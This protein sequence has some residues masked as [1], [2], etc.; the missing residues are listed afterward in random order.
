MNKAAVQHHQVSASNN[1][2]QTQHQRGSETHDVC[3]LLPT[4]FDSFLNIF[5]LYKRKKTLKNTKQTNYENLKVQTA[6]MGLRAAPSL[7]L[8]L[9]HV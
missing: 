9:L 1:S 4:V 3:L 8:R 6:T 7:L 5:T 2:M